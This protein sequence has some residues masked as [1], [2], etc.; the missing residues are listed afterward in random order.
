MAHSGFY[1]LCSRLIGVLEMRNPTKIFFLFLYFILIF[2]ACNERQISPLKGSLKCYV[3]ESLYNVVKAAR[4]S[5]IVRYPGSSIEL[6][7]AKSR[8]GIAS[9]LNQEAKIFISTRELNAEEKA[10]LEKT[11]ID[12]H[13][14]NF[15][16]DAVVPIVSIDDSK[17]QIT[18]QEIKSLISGQTK[19][20]KVFVPEHN[21]GIYEFLK[22]NVLDKNEL[23]NIIVVKSEEEAISKVKAIKRSIGF[24]GVNTLNDVK[25]IKV[26]ELGSKVRSDGDV[27]Y[28]KPYAAYLITQNYPFTR[29]TTIF[30]NE[31]GVGLASGFATYLTSF[32]GQKIVA[33]NNLGPATVPIKMVK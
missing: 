22:N 25:G 32:E 4:D 13:H 10:F 17:F 5:F 7:S 15:C 8:E 28:Y 26:L 12:L 31:I 20:N 16:Y 9:I 2:T 6:V 21:S 11:K 18:V 30:L 1:L 14:F 33:K 24:V 19:N 23:Q 3:D 27:L 29:T